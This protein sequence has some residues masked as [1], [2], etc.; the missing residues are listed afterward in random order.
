MLRAWMPCFCDAV[1]TQT[2]ID[3]VLAN[4]QSLRDHP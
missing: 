3:T 4:H 1:S 2:M